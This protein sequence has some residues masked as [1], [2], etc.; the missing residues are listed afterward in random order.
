[1]IFLVREVGR[2]FVP[3]FIGLLAGRREVQMVSATNKIIPAYPD[4]YGSK[5]KF[6][7]F[8]FNKLS[9]LPISHRSWSFHRI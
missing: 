2:H 4:V 5:K 3:D 7:E 8:D 1:M 6:I 9:Q